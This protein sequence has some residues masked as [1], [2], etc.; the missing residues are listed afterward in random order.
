MLAFGIRTALRF[1]RKNHSKIHSKVL[2]D[3]SLDDAEKKKRIEAIDARTRTQ[4]A[5]LAKTQ[6]AGAVLRVRWSVGHGATR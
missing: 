1:E 5:G 6:V 4:L 3:E 2:A